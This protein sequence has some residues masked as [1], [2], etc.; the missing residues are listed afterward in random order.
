MALNIKFIKHCASLGQNLNDKL[1]L[2]LFGMVAPSQDQSKNRWWRAFASIVPRFWLRPKQL[3]GMR[4]LVN[5]TDW[6]QTVIFEE[7]FLRNVYDLNK[8]S[9]AP[10]VI[11]DC[12]AHVG[13]FSMLAAA[14]FPQARIFA[15]EPN[16]RNAAYIRR[17]V[18]K[19]H[20]GITILESAV[21][22]EVGVH[23]FAG[24]NSHSGRLRK[25]S[26]GLSKYTV[27]TINFP[28]ML[29]E[30]QAKSLLLKMD[31][32]GEEETVVPAIAPILPK[33]SVVFFESHFDNWSQI[34]EAF[35]NF[36]FLV[37]RTN[38][39]DQCSDGIAIRS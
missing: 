22:T 30:L 33:N 20:L 23:E 5:P 34:S 28:A 9:F 7:V 16:P 25:I 17:Q 21:S 3:N 18:Q 11:V 35:H 29:K 24:E 1:L 38:T 8:V 6:S 39:R 36:G 10:E 19:N 32:E 26:N 2:G 27:S 15:F 14:T 13:M 12:G 37:T 4:I 31:I